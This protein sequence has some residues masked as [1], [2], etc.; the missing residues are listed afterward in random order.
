LLNMPQ[1]WEVTNAF[2]LGLDLKA[3]N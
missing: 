3:T 1:N 2:D